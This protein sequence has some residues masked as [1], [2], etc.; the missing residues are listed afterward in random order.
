MKLILTQDVPTCGRKGEIC[1][2][3]TGYARNYLLKNKLATI[4]TEEKIIQ[5]EQKVA[6][7]KEQRQQEQEKTK[8]IVKL[9]DGKTINIVAKN[10]HGTLFASVD[11]KLIAKELNKLV[12]DNV[13]ESVIV[14]NEP[15]K[16]LGEYKIDLN[17]VNNIKASIRLNIT[18]E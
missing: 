5:Y 6:R 8:H 4:A 11:E 13:P 9:L 12:N 10:D 18:G 2:V 3:S 17:F 16:K 15:I 14:I 7:Q 1:S